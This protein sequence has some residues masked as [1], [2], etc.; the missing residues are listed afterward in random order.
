VSY[1]T[2]PAETIAAYRR[3]GVVPLRRGFAGEWL[4]RLAAGVER[5]LREP[6]PYAKRYT[7]VGNPGLFFGDYCSWQRIPEYREFMTASPAASLAAALMGS[8]KVNLYHEHVL[9]K[10]PGTLERTP[11]HHDQPYYPIDGEQIVSLWIPLDPVPR[12]TCPEFIVGSHRWGKWFMPARFKDG[13]Q[14][15]A[16]DPRFV[17]MPD[18]EAERARHA[19]AAF[20]LEPGDCIAFHGLT[21]HGAPGNAL[22]TRRRAFSARWTGDDATFVR[23]PGFMSPP[24]P[25]RD[26][27]CEGAALDSAAFPVVWRAGVGRVYEDAMLRGIPP[28]HA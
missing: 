26:G 23:R 12:A 22:A 13:A 15:E 17:P 5:N 18:I 16:E 27:P 20:D 2:L 14:W 4:D 9:V 24:P 6:G 21:V 7:P 10:E 25:E 19:I 3:D 8:A 11:W 28:E 1:T